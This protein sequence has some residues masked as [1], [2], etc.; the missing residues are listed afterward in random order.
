[1]NNLYTNKH[2]LDNLWESLANT[3]EVFF[4]YTQ[5]CFALTGVVSIIETTVAT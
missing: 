2:I 1:M 4:I 5:L 3:Y